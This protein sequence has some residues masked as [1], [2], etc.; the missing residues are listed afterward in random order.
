MT[1]IISFFFTYISSK[2]KT[3]AVAMLRF[4]ESSKQK[5]IQ[6][7]YRSFWNLIELLQNI[8]IKVY[9]VQPGNLKT[10]VAPIDADTEAYESAKEIYCWINGNPFC[11]SLVVFGLMQVY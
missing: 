5:T 7:I 2:N 3:V 4:F 1:D 11:K 10:D 6:I 8:N 9:A